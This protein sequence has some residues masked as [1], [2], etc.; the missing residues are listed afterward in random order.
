MNTTPA[1]NPV[2]VLDFAREMLAV[3]EKRRAEQLRA[4]TISQEC[5]DADVAAARELVTLAEDNFLFGGPA[6]N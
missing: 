5:H 6:L 4:G 3:V 2:S 1:A